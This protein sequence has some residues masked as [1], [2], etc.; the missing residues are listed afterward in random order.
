[1]AAENCSII[2]CIF[3]RC[4]RPI[5]GSSSNNLLIS[6]SQII[7]S[8]NPSSSILLIS[9]STNIRIINSTFSYNSPSLGATILF[10][11]C[12]NVSIQ[13][14][15]FNHNIGYYGA[16]TFQT[17]SS[18]VI[19]DG[20]TFINN[21]ANSGGAIMDLVTMPMNQF[22]IT[23]SNFNNNKAHDGKGGALYL[24]AL[25]VI[26][27]KCDYEDNTALQGKLILFN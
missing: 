16:L 17:I 25:D 18:S 8:V 24:N 11:N 1:M 27:D 23:N 19:V 4:T 3:N 26:I 7:N 13:N 6:N 14:S 10:V 22:K 20:C 9:T 2:N 15:T 21:T 12:M 5:T